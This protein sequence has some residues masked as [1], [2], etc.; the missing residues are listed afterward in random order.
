MLGSAV[1]PTLGNQA[2]GTGGTLKLSRADGWMSG[3]SLSVPEV[4]L[5]RVW[6]SCPPTPPGQ[7]APGQELDS[8]EA[9]TGHPSHFQLQQLHT[10]QK[11]EPSLIL[12]TLRLSDPCCLTRVFRRSPPSPT[13]WKMSVCIM[14]TGWTQ[15]GLEQSTIAKGGQQP[16][17][18]SA[19]P[20]APVIHCGFSMRGPLRAVSI[21]RCGHAAVGWERASAL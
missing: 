7:L 9:R 10:P 1:S 13:L 8:P 17:W 2:G 3:Y 15:G 19:A 18:P 5:W 6:F 20:P 21:L 11:Q 12:A 14:A 4:G 16:L